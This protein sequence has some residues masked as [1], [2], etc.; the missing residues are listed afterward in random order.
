MLDPLPETEETVV[1]P[2]RDPDLEFSIDGQN[3]TAIP[4]DK[5]V[6]DKPESSRR[7]VYVRRLNPFF[8]FVTLEGPTQPRAVDNSTTQLHHQELFDHV[9][10]STEPTSAR[11]HRRL[12]NQTLAASYAPIAD[13][14]FT[15]MYNDTLKLLHFVRKSLRE[16]D[17]G[18]LDDSLLQERLTHWRLLIS[19]TGY[20]LPE[21]LKSLSSLVSFVTARDDREQSMGLRLSRLDDDITDAVALLRETYKTLLTNISIIDSKRGI[22]EAEAVTRITELAVNPNSPY[23]SIFL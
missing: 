12:L 19:Q 3:S 21:L 20:L 9:A 6:D 8:R 11:L 16:I 10:S 2:P 4:A 17:Q 5:D 15:V 7:S 14:L 23:I 1:G 22:A 13:A 18:T